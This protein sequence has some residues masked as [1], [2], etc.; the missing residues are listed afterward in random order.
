MTIRAELAYEI[1]VA[2]VARMA[3]SSVIVKCV[4]YRSASER[5]GQAA[6]DVKSAANVS[7][8][9]ASKYG[10]DMR[11]PVIFLLTRNRRGIN[12]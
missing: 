4:C 3:V 8:H 7:L 1:T 12:V 10:S 2:E 5:G 9:Q 6:L 11:E